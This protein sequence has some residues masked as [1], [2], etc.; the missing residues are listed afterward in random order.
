[1]KGQ[2]EALINDGLQFPG[3]RLDDIAR[4]LERKFGSSIIIED[5]SL[6]D[7][8]FYA[9]FINGEGL[10]EILS[11]LNIQNH[12]NIKKKENVYYLSN[13]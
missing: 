4:S 7:E 10:N 3:R 9:S 6:A 12:M 5:A 13:K 2:P 8:R 1:M 11:S